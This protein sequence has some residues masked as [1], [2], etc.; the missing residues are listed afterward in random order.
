VVA[1]ST[2][3]RTG[4][5]RVHNITRNT[6]GSRAKIHPTVVAG[7]SGGSPRLSATQILQRVG[8]FTG[9]DWWFTRIPWI[10][11]VTCTGSSATTGPGD[12]V[13]FGLPN[14]RCGRIRGNGLLIR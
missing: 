1:T 4:R 10:V 5:D 3:H 2:N 14:V 8:P 13:S 9:H 12:G 6:R 7:P 11:I